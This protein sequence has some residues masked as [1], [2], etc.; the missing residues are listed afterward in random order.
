[1]NGQI[2]SGYTG[3]VIF[4][5]DLI[6]RAKLRFRVEL[7]KSGGEDSDFFSRFFEVGG[8]IGYSPDAVVYEQV[9]LG[10]TSVAWLLRRS[11]RRGQSHGSLLARRGRPLIEIVL[12]SAKAAF[13]GAGAALF[14]AHAV[15]RIRFLT[16]AALHI[17]VV[18]RLA[19]F[20]EITVY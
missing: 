13:C 8:R 18:A 4:R 19:G 12:A 20:R 7:G 2:K 17:G 11:F 15:R 3:N 5:R 14:F 10:R 6:E 16:R 1:V 9:P